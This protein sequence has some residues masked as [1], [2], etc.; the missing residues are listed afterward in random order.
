M[1]FCL[2]LGFA[3][4]QVQV[5][6]QGIESVNGSSVD[7][8]C[9][10]SLVDSGG[11]TV[12]GGGSRSFLVDGCIPDI[13]TSTSDWADWASQLV[14][15]RRNEGSTIPALDFPHVLL[16]FGFDTAVSLTGIE[17][18]L[19][20][21]PDWNID[22]KSMYVYLNPDYN[23]VYQSGLQFVDRVNSPQSSCDSLSTVTITGGSFLTGSY[24]TF[25][26]LLDLT[27]HDSIE[28]VHVG[29]IRFIGV[30][31][32]TCLQPPFSSSPIL[33]PTLNLPSPS[34]VPQT[35]AKHISTSPFYPTSSHL[36]SVDIL[37]S[38]SPQY[39]TTSSPYSTASSLYSTASTLPPDHHRPPTTRTKTPG[40]TLLITATTVPGPENQPIFTKTTTIL[41]SA[42]AVGFLVFFLLI[43]LFGIYCCR[44]RNQ[45]KRKGKKGLQ[46][47]IRIK[48][49]SLDYD[50]LVAETTNPIQ[51]SFP[52]PLNE[53]NNRTGVAVSDTQYEGLVSR[54]RQNT[55]EDLEYSYAYVSLSE[56]KTKVRYSFRYDYIDSSNPSWSLRRPQEKEKLQ[57]KKV[58]IPTVPV[59]VYSNIPN[60]ASPSFVPRLEISNNEKL[61]PDDNVFVSEHIDPSDF[62]CLGKSPQEKDTPRVYGPVYP[63][64]DPLPG[65][66]PPLN[67]TRD[68]ILEIN[69]GTGEYGHAVLAVTNNL[70]LKDLRLS[71]DN[72]NRN[73]S[74]LLALK[75]LHPKPSA[76]E[77]EDFD[78]EVEFMYQLKHPSIVQFI[79][80]CYETPAFLMM[81]YMEEGD[82]NQFLHRYSEIVP[83]TPCNE[84]QI[85]TSTLIYMASQIASGMKH[86]ANLKFIHRDLATR[87]CFVGNNF[88]VK[89]ADFGTNTRYQ[90]Q[91]YRVRGNILMPIRW[92]A[93]ECFYGKFSEK[94]DVWAFGVTVWELFTLANEVPYSQLSD[95]EV[96]QNSLTREC[97]KFPSKPAAC[98]K[99]VYEVMERCWCLEVKHRATFA[100]I[101]QTLQELIN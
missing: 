100:E 93:T 45:Q 56:A 96:I 61:T 62:T 83:L 43:L 40:G 92:M 8:G 81:E 41:I 32:P 2:F 36:S 87:K 26:I 98:P 47:S 101:D 89:L 63:S 49:S 50:N 10:S 80:V 31:D 90:S 39:S 19:F 64:L 78:R 69:E 79:G 52:S 38:L 99:P 85:A 67:I 94:T 44:S 12:C 66:L 24:H 51:C 11:V 68:H 23:L 54:R 59:T 17:M 14:T 34:S 3:A 84:N 60:A 33:T 1:F 25:H 16:T 73:L 22:A 77:Q 30:N 82:L 72:T 27:Q 65:R 53:Q 58:E 28:W 9:T 29:E 46:S 37:T 75:K 76:S 97:R 5:V 35:S 95:E 70:S 4:A 13:D 7:M 48:A 57:P 55:L 21:C 88:T 74:I 71:K 20:L 18:D 91:Y 15:V 42:V 86:L 6:P